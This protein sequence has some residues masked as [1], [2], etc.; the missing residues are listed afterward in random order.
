[1]AKEKKVN[2]AD[3]KGKSVDELKEI[4]LSLHS[5][6]NQYR[7]LAIKSQGALEAILQMIPK[8]S[9]EEMIKEEQKE[10]ATDES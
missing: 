3:P 4:A 10:L 9:V 1:M 6:A 8:E 5:K 2:I 7:E